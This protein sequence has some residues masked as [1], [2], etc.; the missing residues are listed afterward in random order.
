LIVIDGFEYL[1]PKNQEDYHFSV[2]DDDWEE[3]SDEDSIPHEIRDDWPSGVNPKHQHLSEVSSQKTKT[4]KKKKKV[5]AKQ[6]LPLNKCTLAI[7]RLNREQS[8]NFSKLSLT[9]PNG[10]VRPYTDP[11][12]KPDGNSIIWMDYASP[13]IIGELGRYQKVAWKRI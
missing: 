13:K 2:R 9:F 3:D 5:M 8:I 6:N 12:F 11:E 4:K 1:I 10:T 7:D